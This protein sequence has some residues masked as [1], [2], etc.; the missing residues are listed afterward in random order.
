[1]GRPRSRTTLFCAHLL[2]QIL[3]T[4][5]SEEPQFDI[6]NSDKYV[7][8]KRDGK[9]VFRTIER[10]VTITPKDSNQPSNKA[11]NHIIEFIADGKIFAS[12]ALNKTTVLSCDLVS[13][14]GVYFSSGLGGLP[15]F[16]KRFFYV[17]VPKWDY[18]EYLEIT[19]TDVT[20]IPEMAE[21]YTSRKRAFIKRTEAGVPT[22][23][24]ELKPNK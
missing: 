21:A 12:I 23:D 9:T 18:F 8:Y 4:H 5:F 1:L 15:P 2:K 20:L 16:D 17:C 6:F 14:E 19:D 11:N 22:E 10:T 7:A 3:P 13:V 24:G